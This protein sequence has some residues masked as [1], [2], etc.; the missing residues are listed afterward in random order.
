MITINLISNIIGFM[1]GTLISL[2]AIPKILSILNDPSNAQQESIMRNLM[3]VVGNIMWV[4]Y[5]YLVK[6]YML[7]L[8]CGISTVTNA[9][10]LIV[11]VTHRK[12]PE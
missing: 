3:I 9:I 11:A 5:G 7:V 10:I 6:S 1:A 12:Y 2:S 4:T 8:M